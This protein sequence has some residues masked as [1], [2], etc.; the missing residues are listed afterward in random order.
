MLPTQPYWAAL[1]AEERR[2]Y[3][4]GNPGNTADKQPHLALTYCYLT[5]S[6]ANQNKKSTFCHCWGWNLRPLHAGA[7]LWPLGQVS[8]PTGGMTWFSNWPPTQYRNHSQCLRL[9]CTWS[10][11]KVD[12]NSVHLRVLWCCMPTVIWPLWFYLSFINQHP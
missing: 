3:Y 12:V 8:P 6:T 1:G 5:Q 4:P 9:E 7:P 10:R 2:V 11:C